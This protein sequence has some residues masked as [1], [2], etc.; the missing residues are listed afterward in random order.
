MSGRISLLPLAALLLAA[1]PP[2]YRPA[3]LGQRPDRGGTDI[4]P[5]QFLRGYDP[6]TA[7]FSG[8][9][10][11]GTGPADDGGKLLRIEPAWP[12]AWFW[13]DRK[14][15]QFR[16]AEPW[17]PLRRFAVTAHG[18]QRTLATM[19]SAPSAMQPS[20]GSTDLLPFRT[21]TLTFPQALP[22]ESLRQMLRIEIRDLPGL[23]D[24]PRRVVEHVDLSQLPRRDQRDPAT[25][26][27]TLDDDVPEGKEL[28]V[29]LALAL[30]D[31]DKVLWTGRL[32]TREPFRLR[33]VHCGAAEAQIGGNAKLPRELALACGVHG[34]LPQLVF[35]A[36][37]KD[38]T[39]TALKQLVRLE[40]A[41]PDLSFESTGERVS[42]RGRFVPDV[43]YRM[44]ISAAPVHD[45]TDRPLEDP[46]DAELFFY[47][48]WRTAFLRWSQSTAIL[49]ARGPRMLPLVGYGDARA[50]V[51]VYRVDPL[52][53]GLWPFPASP[54]EIDEHEAP[55]FPGEEPENAG[56]PR[57][58]SPP[59]DLAAHLR[60]LGSPLVSKI[61]DLPLARH[62]GATRFGLDLGGL[63]DPVVGRRRPGTY[64]VGLRRLTGGPQRSYVRVQIT[65]LSL[66]TVEDR[67]Q[68]V[69]WVRA[70][71]DAEG[72]SG[73]HI[74]L[75]GVARYPVSTGGSID[76][77]VSLELRTDGDGK[78]ILGAP[79][80]NWV[81][82]ERLSVRDGDD[83]LVID[84]HEPPP[85]FA[86][87]HWGYASDWLSWLMHP[88]PPPP[89][90]KPLAF[91]F[92]ERP[93]YRPGEVVHVKGF[94]RQKIGGALVAPLP[95]DSYGLKI[96][97]PGDRSWEL[98]LHFSPLHGFAADFA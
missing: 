79:L 27:V 70:L 89:N 45:E 61:V 1:T 8:H 54:V 90:D 36:P 69:F 18:T 22:L 47:R 23:G 4:L 94:I 71:D 30:G 82:I 72:I 3:D 81:S 49:E 2:P 46:G 14:T 19:M 86:S 87:H 84:P 13:V 83:V 88:V 50:D 77:P 32:S 58:A 33:E 96:D 98:P 7:Y 53:T 78:A 11:P 6:I 24:S 43:L 44:E 17:P 5:E 75:E 65:N 12:G 35:S 21:L 97:G 57:S 15:L 92:T 9:E 10:G 55:P 34:E 85:Q 91:V 66:T 29:T 95:E 31:E 26:A 39:L 28:V 51:R 63:L 20:D 76:R 59:D 73:A 37:V 67:D 16:P 80:E 42:L 60:L 74:T 62:A 41:V 52:F 38:L 25:Y 48:G 93:I 40:P 64:L 68:L 56:P